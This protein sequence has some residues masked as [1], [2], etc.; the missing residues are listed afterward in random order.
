MIPG[1]T[2]V[3]IILQQDVWSRSVLMNTFASL[4]PFSRWPLETDTV[5]IQVTW[6]EDGGHTNINVA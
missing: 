2:L 5:T 4:K 3:L 1:K 6:C